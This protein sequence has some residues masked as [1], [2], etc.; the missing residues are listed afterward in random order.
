MTGP[1]YHLQPWWG[2]SCKA[3][4]GDDET[5]TQLMGRRGN[6]RGFGERPKRA[7]ADRLGVDGRALAAFRVAL[8]ATLLLD[9]G[10]RSADLTAFYSDAGVLPRDVLAALYP[11]LAGLSLH[12]LSGAAW[13]QGALF[14]LGAAFALALVVGYRTRLATAASFLLLV[15]VHLRNPLILHG[16][17]VLL[18]QL[19]FWGLLLPLGGRWSVDA[20][21][22][23]ETRDRVVG[24][25]TAGLLLQVVLVYG[26][27]AA[28][29]LGHDAWIAG[30][31]LRYALAL[32]RYT[33][34]LGEVVAGWPALAAAL[35]WAWLGLVI[36]SPL[37]IVLTGRRRAALAGAF[38]AVHLGML[39]VMKLGIFPLVSLAG[40]LPFLPATVWDR[41]PTPRDGTVPIAER[42]P[43][44]PV[45]GDSW[46]AV[47]ATARRLATATAT[48][49]IAAMLVVNAMSLGYVAPPAGTPD[50]VA[51]K[52][53]NMFGNPPR[54]DGWYAMPATLDSGG[55]IDAYRGTAAPLDRPPNR[56]AANR[57]ERWRKLL[58][59][60]RG[61]DRRAARRSLLAYE[62]RRWNGTHETGAT[63]V[64]LVYVQRPLDGGGTGDRVAL[65]SVDC[66]APSA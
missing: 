29:K 60:V 31:A 57:N 46:P 21:R 53:W 23:S 59:D 1:A 65:G 56:S 35:T 41:V 25:A 38:A 62:C 36:C 10:R 27:N 30:D 3:Y 44:A 7:L 12:A 58:D 43:A 55:R 15:S 42:F 51:E 54:D 33:T 16:G 64:D 19:L 40:L 63:S 32:D 39:P 66:R 9:Y 17:D 26:A 34:P 50:A 47:A 14:A 6:G 5:T 22:R 48:A 52:S 20:V 4:A 24:V 37:L 28:F 45:I 18:R 49:G 13:Y 11:S 61:A 2:R 8:G